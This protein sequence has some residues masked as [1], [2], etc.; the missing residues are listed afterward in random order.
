MP[1]V[2]RCRYNG[3]HDY[4]MMPDHYCSKHIDHEAEYIA[5]REQYRKHDRA[6]TWRYNHVTRYRNDTKTAQNKF[7]HT[8][9]WSDLRAMVLQRDYNLCQYCKINTGN[10]V[11]HIIPV[12]IEITRIADPSNMVTCCREC[13][14]IKTQW[15]QQYYGTGLHNVLTG[16]QKISDV[17]LI[18]QKLNAVRSE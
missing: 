4:A 9:Q 1:R 10:I 14:A 13:H 8:K 11:D 16:N 5:R 6:T 17:N 12:E 15:E 2:R 7:Y 18:I 3:C